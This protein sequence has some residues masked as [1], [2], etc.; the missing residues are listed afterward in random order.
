MGSMVSFYLA[1]LPR[2]GHLQQVYHVFGFLK[3][4]PKRTP[5]FDPQHPA[6]DEEQFVECDWHDFFRAA[7]E[8][9]PWDAPV[10]RGNVVSTH[11]FVDVSHAGNRVTRCSQTGILLFVNR[12]PIVWSF[13]LV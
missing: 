3:A 9:I 7:K 1:L 12:A 13:C 8:S 5:A 4:R 11:C 2:E 6:I 10:A